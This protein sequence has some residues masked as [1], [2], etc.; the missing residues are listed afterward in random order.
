M[1]ALVRLEK[2]FKSKQTC[3]HPGSKVEV[4]SSSKLSLLLTRIEADD[5]HY[6]CEINPV[7]KVAN[8]K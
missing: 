6:D 8:Q 7:V 5:S 2:S 1:Q 4:L 3:L